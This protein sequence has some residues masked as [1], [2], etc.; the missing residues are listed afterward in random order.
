MVVDFVVSVAV[1]L[2]CVVIVDVV[3]DS[4]FEKIIYKCEKEIGRVFDHK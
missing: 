4:S 1:L 3:V 2:V